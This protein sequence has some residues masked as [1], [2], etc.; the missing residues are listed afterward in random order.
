MAKIRALRI[1]NFVYKSLTTKSPH[2]AIDLTTGI[3]I[4]I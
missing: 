3:N 1:L 2:L 4:F